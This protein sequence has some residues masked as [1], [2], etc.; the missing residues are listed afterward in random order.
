MNA[1]LLAIVA[2]IYA[3]V[4]IN[5]MRAG[6]YWGALIWAGYVIANIGFIGKYIYG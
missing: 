3:C 2:I 5:L 4:G 1:P 6:D